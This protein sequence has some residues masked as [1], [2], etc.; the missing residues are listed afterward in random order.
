MSTDATRRLHR[1][2]C[3][4]WSSTVRRPARAR[5]ADGQIR[6]SGVQ[7]VFHADARVLPRPCSARR[8]R[9]GA[10][11]PRAGRRRAGRRSSRW[12]GGSAI[13]S[14]TRRSGSSGPGGSSPGGLT[15]QIAASVVDRDRSPVTVTGRR[16]AALRPAPR[17]SWSS[18]AARGRRRAPGAAPADLGRRRRDRVVVTAPAPASTG[19][20]PA[21][22]AGRAAAGRSNGDCAGGSGSP[23]GT[24]CV[25]APGGPVE[26]SPPDG[27]RRRPP[28]G[29]AAR[30]LPR[31]PAPR[32]RLADRPA[33]ATPSSAPA[34]PGSSPCS[35]GTA[36]GRPGC[37]CRSAPTW[38]PARCGCW[39]AARAPGS[40]RAPARR[41]AR[42]CTS[43]AGTTF[44]LDT[45]KGI[46]L[47]A[48]LLR[49]RRRHP[50]VDQPA[51]RRLALGPARRRGRRRCCRTWTPRWAGWPS[52]PTRT[53]TASSSTSTPAG[54]GLANQG[55]KDSGDAVRFHDGRLAE[56]PIA[57]VEV[58][59]YAYRAALDAAALLDAFAT[60]R[61]GR[62]L[63]AR[64]AAGLAERF[65]ARVL[66]R[67]P[68]AYPALALDRRQ[69]PGR[70]ADQQHRPPA[71][72]RPARR[73]RGAAV[74]GR[75]ARRPDV[76]RRT[77][78][79]R[80]PPPTA[81]S[82]R[83]PTTAARSG[84]TTP[85]SSLPAWPA[86]APTRR[87]AN[88]DRRA[89]R[90][91]PRRS[92]TGCPS[93]TPATPGPRSAARCPTPAPAARRRGRRRPP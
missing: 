62:P 14:P 72:H 31:R 79:A 8:P 85:R 70:R 50:A 88:A 24:R 32:L 10:D 17:S 45:A 65:R 55:W 22:L 33:R 92:T 87:A 19:R 1:P 21:A 52:T 26:W 47:P 30:P 80:C 18:P 20:T 48:G 6:P 71:R 16:R 34:C 37:C 86:R 82:R 56:P 35:A 4:T 59:G 42:S 27:A 63:A 75:A 61:G 78:C 12:P 57:L 40:T 49:H 41:P 93:S 77:G 28:P 15:E 83:C 51:A 39:P 74:A 64:Y 81:A 38:P 54:R 90:R 84:R 11:R 91:P 66:G 68:A 53:A 76:R 89:A 7:G 69:A 60:G 43:C 25:A 44:V 9:A 73:G 2:R 58:Q 23:T 13:R 29:P 46:R 3:T 36:S 5:G 67:R